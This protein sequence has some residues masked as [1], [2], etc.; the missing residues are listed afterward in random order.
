M[1]SIHVCPL[2][3]LDETLKRSGAGWMI[4]L[5]GPGKSPEQPE[6]INRGY[7]ALEFNDISEP[8][9]GLIPP[10][11]NDIK[12]LLNFIDSWRSTEQSD[13]LL[14]HCWMGI[15][16]STAAALI[17]MAQIN[18]RADPDQ[19]AGKL[20]ELS[21]V[22]TPNPLMISIADSLLELDYRLVSAVA[23]IGRGQDAFEGVP[24]KMEIDV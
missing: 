1:S 2:S 10:S 15:S 3:K 20:R 14:I 21:P 24:F 5:S 4:S 13:P 6:Q 17:A 22:A 23:K 16:R 8:R 19:L 18:P 7:L 11:E 12:K 9:E